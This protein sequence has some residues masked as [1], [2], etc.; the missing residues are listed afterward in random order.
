MVESGRDF[1]GKDVLLFLDRARLEYAPWIGAE[2]AG[3]QMSRRDETTEQS[4]TV[5]ITREARD[6]AAAAEITAFPVGSGIGIEVWSNEVV[7]ELDIAT[8]VRTAEE[9]IERCVVR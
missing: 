5:E 8:V 9:A 2:G 6:A 4:I 1:A 7:I 3:G